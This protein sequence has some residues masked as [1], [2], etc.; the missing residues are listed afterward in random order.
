MLINCNKGALILI[1]T[2]GKGW[3]SE[4]IQ[5]FSAHIALLRH[6]KNDLLFLAS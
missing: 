2:V 4:L 5:A 1:L 6:P 3:T